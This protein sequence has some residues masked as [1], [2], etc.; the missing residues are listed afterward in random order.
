MTSS[1]LTRP[2]SPSAPARQEP[3]APSPEDGCVHLDLELCA[4]GTTLDALA[5]IVT[6]LR[7]R[8]WDV[9]AV[10]ADLDAGVVRLRVRTDRPELLR[11]Q[12]ERVAVVGA[13]VGAVRTP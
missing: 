9:R 10:D 7:G 6:M 2:D 4:P 12:L 13:V 1:M 8:R 11:G 5:K 3:G